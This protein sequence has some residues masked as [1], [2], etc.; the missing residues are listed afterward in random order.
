MHFLRVGV[1]SHA[2]YE[3]HKFMEIFCFKFFF[4]IFLEKQQRTLKTLSNT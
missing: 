4:F 1:T 2:K 3:V